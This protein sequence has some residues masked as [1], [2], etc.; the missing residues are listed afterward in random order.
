MPIGHALLAAL[1]MLAAASLQ[2]TPILR[3]CTAD[4]PF[5]PYTMPDGS[6]YSQQLIRL[7]LRGL[8]L[9]LKN[10]MAPRARCLQDSRS[11]QADAL[12]GVYASERLAWL[13]YP[14]KA[15]E[16]DAAAS[17]AQLR[18]MVY[19]RSGSTADWD[20]KRFYHLDHGAIGVQF[21]FSYGLELER[22]GVP[23]DDK[24]PSAE[25]VLLKLARGRIPLAVLQE[26]QGQ[27]LVQQAFAG[28]IEA[29]PQPFMQQNLYL[30]VTREFQA[31]HPALVTQLWA[32]IAGARGSPEYLRILARKPR[33][34]GPQ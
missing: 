9:Q 7:A 4:V 10:H 24:A 28:K 31:R 13:S 30:I 34:L 29:L 26:E 14:M 21:G 25:Q 33:P 3:L 1:M 17:L 8:P 32:A 19:R 23:L 15:G 27:A 20:G 5:Y 6:G 12:V 22:L 11:G 2:A 18:F 16:P